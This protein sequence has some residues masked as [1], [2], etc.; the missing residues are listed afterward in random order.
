LGDQGGLKAGH[1]AIGMPCYSGAYD[2]ET[3]ACI[4]RMRQ[5]LSERGIETTIIEITGC[6]RVDAV[7][8]EIVHAFLA[9]TDA[10]SLL[11]IDSDMVWE[12]KDVLR[13]VRLSARYEFV[14]G[15]YTEKRDQPKFDVTVNDGAANEDGLISVSSGPLGFSLIRRSVFEEM[16]PKYPHLSYVQTKGTH[17]GDVIHALHLMGLEMM[18][19][20]KRVRVGEDVAF[21]LRWRKI[22]G[23][24]WLDPSLQLGHIGRK[25]YR[26][27]YAS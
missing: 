16:I 1:L 14:M 17:E 12:P 13:L 3:V 22:G 21:C 19:H 10:Q 24:I 25:V 7:R 23:K 9:S 4:H 15:A 18:E 5:A 6:G 8:D 26:G 11:W 2:A 20:G 27:G